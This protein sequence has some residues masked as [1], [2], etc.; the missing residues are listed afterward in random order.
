MRLLIISTVVHYSRDGKSVGHGP[1]VTEI[2]YLA[3]IFEEISHIACYRSGPASE[4][5]LPYDTDRVGLV[6]VPVT[7][8]PHLRDKLNILRLAPQYIRTMLR[9]LPRAD[10]VHIRC[11]ANISLLA[12]VLLAFVRT[13]Q[14]RWVKYAG[15]WQ[16]T[17]RE[18]WSSRFQRWW[19]KRGF[20]RG[21]VTVNGEWPDQ[22]THVRSFI[23]PC[24]TDEEV[25][26]AA[27]IAQAK[28][29]SHPLRLLFVGAVNGAKGVG[30]ALQAVQ[31]LRQQAVPVVLDIIGDGA[32]RNEFQSM[33]AQLGIADCVRF[34]GA[35]PR[36]KLNEFYAQ[37][38]IMVFPTDS[39]EGWPKI[40]SESMAYGV[41][42]VSGNVSSI[43]QYLER[44][45]VGQ[46]LDPYDVEAF[47]QAI[48]MYCSHPDIWKQ[49]SLNGLE[50]AR[51]FTY[52]HY[53]QDVSDLLGLTD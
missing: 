4:M 19:L 41:V 24:L 22:P 17:R 28:T 20:H 13:P 12:I 8:G 45:Q 3:Q 7:G 16:P 27:E 37:A 14:L 25:Q 15:N 29:L 1:T 34:H 32:S 2:S 49:E 42:P 35:L 11:P 30:R 31:R 38:H 46:A 51:Q 18:P 5:A 53:L 48:I 44:F 52:S 47:T 40:L 26:I 36:T 43:P 9:E 33:A 23:N 21:L 50:L 6:L 39:S 10:V